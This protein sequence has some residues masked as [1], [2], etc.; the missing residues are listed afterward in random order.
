MV[1]RRDF[2]I[3][4]LAAGI[5]APALAEA[6]VARR[7]YRTIS[8]W[9]G[10]PPGGEGVTVTPRAILRSP[11]SPPDDLAFYGITEPT[12]TIVRP[13]RPNGFALLMAPG[14][15]YERIATSPDGGGLAHFLAGQGFTVGALLYRLPYDGWA[16]GPDAPFQDAQ[17]AFRL[18]AREAGDGTRVGVV[19]FSAGGHVA[20]SLA[21]RFAQRSYEAVDADDARPA[22]PA[23]AGLFFPVIT[24]TE[25]YAHGPSRRNLIGKVPDAER[26]RRWSLEQNVPADMPPTFVTAAADDRTVPVENSL[27]MFAALRRQKVPS[28][29][30]IFDFGG[31]GFGKPGD[32]TGPGHFWPALFED[33]LRR[34][35]I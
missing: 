6:G 1:D 26:I 10:R 24:M 32:A 3:G 20:G 12:L 16:A 15:G 19:G 11:T 14:G 31:H 18:L 35:R 23:F 9:P 33:W 28:A 4:G 2:L 8:L 29:I 21:S 27:M 13:E 17:R 25:P 34:Q 7:P 5:A 30:H 22:R